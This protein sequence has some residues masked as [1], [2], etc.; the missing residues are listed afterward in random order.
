MDNGSA[1]D[2]TRVNVAVDRPK[3]LTEIAAGNSSH[4][5]G[6]QQLNFFLGLEYLHNNA[7]VHGDLRAVSRATQH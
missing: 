2:Y 4:I 6:H 3:L 7:I 1:L 5:N